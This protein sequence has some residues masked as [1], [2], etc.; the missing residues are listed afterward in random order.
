MA[1]RRRS[2]APV[3]PRSRG[4]RL[5]GRRHARLLDPAAC[6]RQAHGAFRLPGVFRAE[7]DA[8][9]DS[10]DDGQSRVRFAAAPE[11]LS[12]MK[13]EDRDDC[14]DERAATVVEIGSRR[15]GGAELDLTL[16]LGVDGS[17]DGWRYRDRAMKAGVR[18]HVDDGP[19][20]G[21]GDRARRGYRRSGG[22][23][24]AG[25]Q[26]AE[27]FQEASR[28]IEQSRSFEAADAIRRVVAISF[29]ESRA[30]REVRTRA[31]D[32][33]GLSYGRAGALCAAHHGDRGGRLRADDPVV[34]T[35][36][37][38]KHPTRGRHVDS[39]CVRWGREAGPSTKQPRKREDTKTRRS[40]NSARRLVRQRR[41]RLRRC[42]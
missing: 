36:R 33:G 13:A 15:A 41:A 20:C 6:G 42:G 30:V 14:L 3:R 5:C 12:M 40:V 24:M 17:P 27:A 9:L 21:G 32:F 18:V 22:E 34:T 16:R 28:I 39:R 25:E 26:G 1:A 2:P 8:A 10:A 37:E 11:L 7:R 19:V 29:G 4:L 31:A 38:A 23:V 35:R